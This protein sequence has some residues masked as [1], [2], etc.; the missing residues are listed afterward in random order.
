MTPRSSQAN[1][2]PVDISHFRKTGNI[3]LLQKAEVKL[4]RE[5]LHIKVVGDF[6]EIEV[7]YHLQN[8]GKAQRIQYGFPVDAYEENWHY[9]EAHG[10]VFE[11]RNQVVDYFHILENEQEIKVVFWTI[12][13][14]YSAQTKNLGE[15]SFHFTR[16]VTILRRWYSTTLDFAAG[17]RKHL[18][19]HYQVRNT[20]R[21]KAPG[22]RFIHQFTQRHFTYHLTPSSH[23]GEGLVDTFQVQ[24]DLNDL[25]PYK[26]TFQLEGL[27]FKKEK[28]NIFYFKKNKYNL[29][30]ADRIEV[31]YDPRPQLLARFIEEHLLYSNQNLTIKSSNE[32]QLDHLFD[33]DPSTCWTGKSGDWIEIEVPYAPGQTTY[34]RGFPEGILV[35]N[36]NYTD[37]TAFAQS[38]KL[39]QYRITVN[40][41]LVYNHKLW[42][43]NPYFGP[44]SLPSPVFHSLSPDLIKGLATILADGEGLYLRRT[45]PRKIR[46]E[47]L[48][49]DG[50]A[51][52]QISLAELYLLGV[53]PTLTLVYPFANIP[54][55]LFVRSLELP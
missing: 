3:R 38:G 50:T 6:T 45:R 26:T 21:D 39:H 44:L 20:K 4:L 33:H 22:F 36:G 41:T 13:S 55:V 11:E 15:G 12:D 49:A 1:G 34:Q 53:F 19:V 9:G 18:K 47:L 51:A 17:E 23:W 48:T 28:E 8:L 27:D 30:Q 46:I 54:I 32:Q 40:D 5:D 25:R 29:Q 24:V 35:L 42:E 52:N 16:P 37:T 14:L 2:G 7:D 10:P 43:E 31:H